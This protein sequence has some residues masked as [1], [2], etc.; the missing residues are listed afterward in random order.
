MEAAAGAQPISGGDADSRAAAIILAFLAARLVLAFLI[1]PGIDESYTEAIARRLSLSYFDHPPLHQWMAHFAA[2]AFGE[3]APARLPFIALFAATGWIYYRLT[4]DLFGR[5]AATIAL[6][7]LNVTPFFFGPAGGWVL[8]DGPLIFSLAL[9]AWAGA[10]LFFSSP[11]RAS[12][13]RLWLIAG[14]AFGLAGLSKYSAALTAFSFAAFLAIAPSQRRWLRDPALYAAAALALAMTAPVIVWNADHGWASFVFQGSRGAP[15][16]G[17]KPLQ[18]AGMALGEIAYLTPWIFAPLAA[19]LAAAWRRR[20]DERRLYLLCLALPPIVLFTLAP[21]WGARGFPHWT[22]PGWFFAFA[23]MG[24]WVEEKA[25]SARTLRRWGWV[26][27][28]LLATIAAVALVQAATGCPLR[29]LP[30]RPGLADPTLE[31]FDWR[32][33]REAP[34]FHPPP[35]FVVSTKWSDAGKI[36][37]A[38]GPDIPIFVVST[39]PRGWAFVHGSETVLGRDG[40]LVMR[41]SDLPLA[42]GVERFGFR[43]VGE[44][45]FYALM[46]NGRPEI[47]LALVPAK[48]LARGLPSP[49]PTA[50]GR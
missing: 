13:W 32:A 17:L 20:T 35:A 7:G 3:G 4:L 37:L 15:A 25:V 11:D 16:G 36:A 45:Q 12:A 48:G 44:P 46:R 30:L 47:S 41:A 23:L 38:L 29:W 33:L 5:D 10:R 22:M 26:S 39:D 2:L 27:C 40:L 21:L 8:P 43:K 24:A 49:Y 6:F 31:A 34:A 19:G 9:A 50:L 28:T 18:L 1:G 42:P 14:L